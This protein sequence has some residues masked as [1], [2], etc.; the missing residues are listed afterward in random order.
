MGLDRGVLHKAAQILRV[1]AQSETALGPTEVGRLTGVDRSTAHRILSALAQEQLVER[2]DGRYELGSGL[3]ALGLVAAGR[4]DVR[5]VARRHLEALHEAFGETV[6]LAVLDG[7]ALL[8]VDMIESRHELRMAAAVGGRD[9]LTSTALGKAML[10]A[11]P[12][13]DRRSL[14]AD[15]SLPQRTARSIGTRAELE[16]VLKDV[17]ARGYALDLEENEIGACCIGAAITG[18][19]DRL[20]GAIS[21]S[22]PMARINETRQEEIASAVIEAARRSSADLNP[23]QRMLT[24][25]DSARRAAPEVIGR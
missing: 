10:A 21:V 9:S 22:L 5:R 16:A 8:Y 3:A 11:L 12:D 14:I 19:G 24:V 2:Q 6:N 25:I 7:D 18:P 17:S 20:A 23:A 1:L 15:L 4:M 13:A